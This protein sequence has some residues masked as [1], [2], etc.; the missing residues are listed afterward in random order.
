LTYLNLRDR[1]D[2]TREFRTLCRQNSSL[3]QQYRQQFQ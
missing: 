1:P 2:A 3:C